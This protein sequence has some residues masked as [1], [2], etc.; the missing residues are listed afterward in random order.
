MTVVVHVWILRYRSTGSI[1]G[2]VTDKFLCLPHTY[3]T[4]VTNKFLASPQ[5]QVRIMRLEKLVSRSSAVI[6]RTSLAATPPLPDQASSTSPILPSIAH[7]LKI[8][9]GF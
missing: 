7:P 8:L 5:K 9:L 6:T 2:P 3:V 1:D 4:D